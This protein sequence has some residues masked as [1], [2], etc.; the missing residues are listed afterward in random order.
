MSTYNLTD[1]ESDKLKIKDGESISITT[2]EN[3][4]E[5]TVSIPE[6]DLKVSGTK[7]NQEVL[8]QIEQDII[9][10]YLKYENAENLT[11]D[12]AKWKEYLDSKIERVK[13]DKITD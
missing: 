4:G 6:L 2:A 7:G 8:D 13:D 11:G 1:L 12:P 5:F 9:D 3:E 10:L